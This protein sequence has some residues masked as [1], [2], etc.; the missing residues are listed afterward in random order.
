MYQKSELLALGWPTLPQKRNEAIFR[1]ESISH[2]ILSKYGMNKKVL[3]IAFYDREAAAHG[4][5]LPVAVLYQTKDEYLTLQHEQGKQ[6][7]KKSK[8][9]HILSLNDYY[10][11]GNCPAV[12][13][14]IADEKR[15]R[16]F[17]KLQVKKEKTPITH[18]IDTYQRDILNKRNELI[19]KKRADETDRYMERVP[20]LP[21]AFDRWLDREPLKTSRYVY[22]KR[23]S[24]KRA[25]CFCTHC[26]SDFVMEKTLPSHNK[27]G[28]CQSCGS[29]VI[30]K[31]KGMSR[32]VRDDTFTAIIQPLSGGD[33]V[34]RFFH[35]SRFFLDHHRNPE[36]TSYENARLF[37]SREGIIVGQYKYGHSRFTGRY[38]W[39]PTKDRIVGES[40]TWYV[41]AGM[42]M[43]KWND[44][45]RESWLYPH[46]VR[47]MLQ[48]LGLS[49]RI[50]ETICG[51]PVNV[52]THLLQ[53][54]RYP[55]GYLLRE[56]GMD[57]LVED[58]YADGKILNSGRKVGK[59]HQCLGIP[60]EY[61]PFIAKFRLG[62]A[63]VNW[64]AN[65]QKKPS[66]KEY[67]W[68]LKNVKDY[69]VLDGLLRYTTY[70]KIMKY[71]TEQ[72][73]LLTK[74]RKECD[75]N[76][77]LPD[78]RYLPVSTIMN[79]LQFWKDNLDMSRRLGRDMKKNTW[80][81]PKD[82]QLQHDLSQQLI[83]VQ[84]NAEAD[85]E[86]QKLYTPLSQ[87][88][89]YATETF[90]IRPPHNFTEIIVEGNQLGHCVARNGYHK[91]HI[92][93]ET[94]I[95]FIRRTSDPG[96]PYYTL[97]LEPDDMQVRQCYGKGHAGMTPK[98]SD[99]I[100]AWKNACNGQQRKA[101]A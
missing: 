67:R 56:Q 73:E 29:A 4:F 22:Y 44:W 62:A 3:I 9:C 6:I 34:L 2:L 41:S 43:Q 5:N 51:S 45:F 84:K 28:H 53:Q 57:A 46:T 77:Q 88:Y 10:Y 25:A 60:K 72:H 38:G 70:H 35:T 16:T 27:E 37:F 1:V 89:G 87:K 36:T 91:K 14:T 8:I 7:W 21:A 55:F 81:F 18:C 30:Y 15:I 92:T 32:K 52:T 47:P 24:P 74:Q 94:L 48:K 26:K 82:V 23:I 76:Y 85:R 95:F 68:I 50:Q 13:W 64:L 49:Y 90:M 86:I 40:I 33:Y 99:F 58:I 80:L 71:A 59:I 98:I 93:G 69:A 12:C 96:T 79:R 83:Q 61:L 100:D 31:A 19:K 17:M 78:G 11:R 101:A 20:A 63:D 65:I 66:V 42:Y 54:I 39:Y 75:G 97:E